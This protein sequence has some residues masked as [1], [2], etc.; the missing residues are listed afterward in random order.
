MRN[1]R[2]ANC[3]YFALCVYIHKIKRV[4]ECDAAIVARIRGGF[5]LNVVY[6]CERVL[7]TYR[8]ESVGHSHHV[9]MDQQIAL[10]DDRVVILEKHLPLILSVRPLMPLGVVGARGA[11]TS[12]RS[13]HNLRHV[14]DSMGLH[15]GVDKGCVRLVHMMLFSPYCFE[16]GYHTN[17]RGSYHHGD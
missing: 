3:V 4:S 17:V 5:R 10:H 15:R 16:V 2:D 13:C 12:R 7:C 9:C 1:A 8:R 11:T 14:L 6:M